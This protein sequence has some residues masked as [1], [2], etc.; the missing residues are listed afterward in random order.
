MSVNEKLQKVLASAGFDSRRAIERE[1]SAG[2]VT[3]NGQKATLGVRVSPGDKIVYQGRAFTVP[4]I[5]DKETRV[6]LYNKPEGE[7]CSREDPEGRSTVYDR[8]PRLVVGRWI[9]IGRLDI[10][11][12]GLLLF[13]NDGELANQLMHPSSNI[14]REYL[15]RVHGVVTDQVRKILT[16][17][18]LLDDG[19]A[20]FTDIQESKNNEHA[21]GT[22]R[23]FYCTVMEGRNREVRRLWESQDL[24]VSRLKRVRFGNIFIPSYVRNGQ[25]VELNDKELAELYKTAGLAAPRRRRFQPKTAQ[26]RERNERKL[27]SAGRK[28]G[29]KQRYT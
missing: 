4:A 15:V 5:A 18:V 13:T 22:N 1:V 25:W 8:L 6:L 27:K 24:K 16:E 12:S 21:H 23:W 7:I 17:G 11:T 29:M 26:V 10:N 9:S 3:L 19:I 28:G 2:L 14:D 20:K